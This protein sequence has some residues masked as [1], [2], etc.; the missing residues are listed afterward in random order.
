M[1][2]LFTAQFA[3]AGQITGPLV[4]SGNPNYFKDANGKA[5]ILSGSQTWNTLQDWGSNGS[6]QALDFNAYVSHAVHHGRVRNVR[7]H[8][9]LGSKWASDVRIMVRE[10][11]GKSACLF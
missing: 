9:Q 1:W 8:F 4:A 11:F 7:V 5:L 3:S 2:V 6:Q 10:E